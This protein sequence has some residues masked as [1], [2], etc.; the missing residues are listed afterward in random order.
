MKAD[1]ASRP[2][3]SI[4]GWPHP[5]SYLSTEGQDRAGPQ[6][7]PNR[8]LRGFNPLPPPTIPPHQLIEALVEYIQTSQFQGILIQVLELGLF[9]II[10]MMPFKDDLLLTWALMMT[11]SP[12]CMSANIKTLQIMIK[13]MIIMIE[14]VKVKKKREKVKVFTNKNTLQIITI[15]KIMIEK[16][17]SESEKMEK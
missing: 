2:K 13:I 12:L 7:D 8:P 5:G 4:T 6:F 17:K 14:K 3:N 15:V 1:H 10:I 16:R 11:L 9:V